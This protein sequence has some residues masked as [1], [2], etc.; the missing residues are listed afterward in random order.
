GYS[1]CAM[2]DSSGNTLP[3]FV[4]PERE[5]LDDF[6]WLTRLRH[7]QQKRWRRGERPLVEVYLRRYLMLRRDPE[8]LLDMIYQEILL[9][10]ERGAG[11]CRSAPGA[12]PEL[13]LG[14]LLG[15]G[16]ADGTPRLVDCLA[17]LIEETHG[18][19]SGVALAP[20]V[21][22]AHQSKMHSGR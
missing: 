5:T 1:R 21:R 11:C 19:A 20:R 15:C 18:L 7:D 10:E 13:D 4:A 22:R 8:A 6:D 9:R 12:P 16:R 17:E 3:G 2:P 14:C